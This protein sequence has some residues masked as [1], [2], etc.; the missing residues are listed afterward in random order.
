MS[1]NK[2]KLIIASIVVLFLAC[3]NSDGT[4]KKDDRLQV[5]VSVFPLYD[6]AT[7][8]GGDKVAATMLIP[9][10]T[11]ALDYELTERDIDLAATADVFM[12]VSFEMEQ[13]AYKIINTASEKTNML[14]VET[15][16]GAFLLPSSPRG[17]IQADLGLASPDR[18]LNGGTGYDPYIWLD[19]QNAQTMIDNIAAA[20]INKDPKNAGLYKKNAVDYRRRLGRLDGQYK[21]QLSACRSR[22]VLYAGQWPF[23][24]Q[25]QRYGLLYLPAYDLSADEHPTSG[26][27]LALIRQIK[28]QKFRHIFYGGNKVPQMAESVAG[29]TGAVL[30]RLSNGQDVSRKEI[31]EGATFLQIMEG[32]LEKLKRGMVCL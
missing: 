15:G 18:E 7:M 29:E 16:R 31:D 32:N 6:F 11:D 26:Q 17:Q 1:A 5:V 25:A 20:F 30:L 9:P 24:Y 28:K 12:F 2:A 8:V 13:W 10:G 3:S 23:A 21:E 4:G 14:A 22:N 27:T 19:F